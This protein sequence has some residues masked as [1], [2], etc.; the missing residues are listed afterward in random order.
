[1]RIEFD[2]VVMRFGPSV[3][4]DGISF[5]AEEGEFLCLL[6]PSG[7]GKST[8]LRIIAG[9]L[10]A[11]SGTVRV[12]GGP[13]EERYRRLAFVFQNLRLVPWRTALGNVLLGM[14]LRWDGGLPPE[15]DR[16]AHRYLEMV[17]LGSDSG[18]YPG[19]LS[20]GERQ[21]VALARAL[22]VE[23]DI[24][25]MDEPLAA[26]DIN[27][28]ERLREEVIRLWQSTGKTVLFVTH[29]L[30][31]ALYLADRFIILTEKPTRILQAMEL[32]GRRPRDL[33][34]DPEVARIR[35]QMRD[36]F[37]GM[38]GMTELMT[39]GDTAVNDG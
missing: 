5:A 34:R 32:P 28:R 6:G 25:L 15:A 30:D 10:P 1:M 26:L 29:D 8:A 11:T 27:T 12:L 17:G 2:R 4:L 39:A 22:A 9:L 35:G 19:M 7:C 37:R 18:K 13:P 33:F 20:G 14:E 3:V 31:E 38:R 36:L 23:P 21:R 16:R 24:V